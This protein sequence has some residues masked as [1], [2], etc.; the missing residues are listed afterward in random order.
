MRIYARYFREIEVATLVGA[1]TLG[2]IASR[3]VTHGHSIELS[4]SIA[5][6][7]DIV[8][9]YVCGKL[10]FVYPPLKFAF[11]RL[12]ICMAVTCL[13][14]DFGSPMCPY[15]VMYIMYDCI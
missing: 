5:N 11:C 12:H 10:F 4:C 7:D 3:A 6:C 14:V 15:N 8:L 13:L 1:C 9:V 2:K